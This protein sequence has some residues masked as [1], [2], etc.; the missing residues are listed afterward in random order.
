MSNIGC[1]KTILVLRGKYPNRAP[2]RHRLSDQYSA[3]YVR[4]RF[5]A[6]QHILYRLNVGQLCFGHVSA[7]IEAE[8]SYE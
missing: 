6:V 3:G 7:V 5:Q 1:S 8:A 2:L 4:M